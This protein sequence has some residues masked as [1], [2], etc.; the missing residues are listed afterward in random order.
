MAEL[1]LLLI[2]IGGGRSLWER[3]KWGYVNDYWNF[4]GTGIYNNLNDWLISLG[5]LIYLGAI[6][7]KKPH[8]K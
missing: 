3:W 7:K 1:G 5:L 6:W 4:L 8:R 2:I